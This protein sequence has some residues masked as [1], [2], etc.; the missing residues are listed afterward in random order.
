MT[1]TTEMSHLVKT[2]ILYWWPG[3]RKLLDV[4]MV[5]GDFFGDDGTGACPSVELV[6][7]LARRS[8]R[9]VE[10]HIAEL[11]RIGFL[12][13]TA[14]GGG[15]RATTYSCARFMST[16][17]MTTDS[18][19]KPAVQRPWRLPP[20]QVP[21]EPPTAVTGVGS[22]PP[23]AATPTPDSS[24]GPPPTAAPGK[25]VRNQSESSSAAARPVDAP[26]VA[27]EPEKYDLNGPNYLR[28]RANRG[29]K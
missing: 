11:R 28:W 9:T 6:A 19:G 10:R 13:C 17:P 15:E 4:A 5:Y 21:G 12:E 16:V 20:A 3:P 18:K 8:H 7:K 14:P 25:S 29:L 22:P 24:G 1:A 23:T 27:R 2:A 26:R